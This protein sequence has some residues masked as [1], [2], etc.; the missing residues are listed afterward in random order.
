MLRNWYYNMIDHEGHDCPYIYD[1][2]K[3]LKQI[4][5]SATEK[6]EMDEPTTPT[7]E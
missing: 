6:L 7:E 2:L 5:E 3:G 1:V 4:N